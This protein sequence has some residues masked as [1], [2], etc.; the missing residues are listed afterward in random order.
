MD[1]E[2]V[3]G[4]KCQRD[5][6]LGSRNY[7]SHPWSHITIHSLFQEYSTRSIQYETV[8]NLTKKIDKVDKTINNFLNVVFS[9]NCLFLCRRLA[10][11]FPIQH[12]W[13]KPTQQDR[14]RPIQQGFRLT[15]R[16]RPKTTLRRT[17]RPACWCVR[18]RPRARC[19]P[20]PTLWPTSTLVLSLNGICYILTLSVLFRKQPNNFRRLN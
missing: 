5:H 1:S 19:R 17:P 10:P 9:S 6:S 20:S 12:R 2:Y 14:F 13:L 16:H 15:Q 7:L 3:F 18:R 8:L 4:I 11:T